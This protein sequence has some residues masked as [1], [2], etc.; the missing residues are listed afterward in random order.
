[1]ISSVVEEYS[2]TLGLDPH[3]FLDT[4]EC[5]CEPETGYLVVAG[6]PYSSNVDFCQKFSNLLEARD[7]TCT[8]FHK[9]ERPRL[10]AVKARHPVT[11]NNKKI[12][13]TLRIHYD[14]SGALE[15]R[16][17]RYTVSSLV[18]LL[19]GKEPPKIE[20]GVHCKIIQV[21]NKPYLDK[22][23][24]HIWSIVRFECNTYASFQP[25]QRGKPAIQPQLSH[26]QTRP[27]IMQMSSLGTVPDFGVSSDYSV[28]LN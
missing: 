4:C 3:K 1:V 17:S 5:R 10:E 7:F 21:S 13:T 23:K 19:K 2:K 24:I 28:P 14:A 18:K 27:E 11:V 26:A 16:F 25:T 20:M 15:F 8:I 6:K 12:P 22:E 9:D